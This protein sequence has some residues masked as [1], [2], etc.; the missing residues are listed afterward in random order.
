MCEIA[1][2]CMN[3]KSKTLTCLKWNYNSGVLTRLC[4]SPNPSI[5]FS[6][7]KKYSTGQSL[8][9]SSE[10]MTAIISF[11]KL[12]RKLNLI[13]ERLYDR[14]TLDSRTIS[15]LAALKNLLKLSSGLIISNY[16]TSVVAGGKT[17]LQ[18]NLWSGR[19]KSTL[20]MSRYSWMAMAA[21]YRSV[22]SSKANTET[23]SYTG[24]LR[25]ILATDR[26]SWE[27]SRTQFSPA[28]AKDTTQVV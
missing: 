4:S 15:E 23:A 27:P 22:N 11:S 26:S 1:E 6:K 3:S 10:P 18:I 9:S 7:F 20:M 28:P 14:V 2:V 16:V 17:Q 25:S 13:S 24:R 12:C 21:M 5:N 8:I 19:A